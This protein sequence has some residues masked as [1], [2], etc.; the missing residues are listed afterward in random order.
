MKNYQVA[1]VFENIAD[2]MEID[3]DS[4]F[5]IRAYRQAAETMRSLTS[6]LEELAERGELQEIPGVGEAIEAKTLQILATGTCDLYERLRKKFPPSIIEL[7]SLPGVGARTVRSIYEGLHVASLEELKAAAQA[8]RL[9]TL[10][11]MGAKAEQRILEGIARLE[12]RPHGLPIVRALA[13]TES[14]TGQLAHLAGARAVFAAGDCRRYQEICAAIVAVAA[15]DNPSA[16]LKAFSGG[17]SKAEIIEERPD[18]VRVTSDLGPV[19]CY[20]EEPA[21]AG[22]ALVRATGSRTHLSHLEELAKE[23]GL[24]FA[25][26]RLTRKDG[27]PLEAPDEE[28]FY[29]LLGLPWIAPEIRE[30]GE[31]IAAAQAGRLPELISLPDI[32]GDLHS[33]TLDSDGAATAAEMAEA[34][35]ERGYQYLAITDHSQSLTVAR[36]LTPER[37]RAQ[38][39]VI[40]GINAATTG[41]LLLRGIEVDIKHDGS[42]DLPD[43]VLEELDW[44]N[45]SIH[46]AFGLPEE[47][48][49]ARAL[50]AV[51][52][53]HVDALSHPTGRQIGVRD[54][55]PLD[56]DAVINAALEHTT[57]LEIN[58]FPDRLDLCGP[59]ARRAR[60]AGVKIAISTDSHRPSHLAGIIHGIGTARRGWLTREDVLNT[61]SWDAI[62]QW[63]APK[64]VQAR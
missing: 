25:G 45:A 26:T 39:P 51:S 11:K 31:E 33:H 27:G 61:M 55:Y 62:R 12:A 46:S 29:R 32:V 17:F 20:V 36:G 8:G 28:T 10:P 5:K 48:M 42:L 63:K 37:V 59:D 43:D 35:R 44:V 15:S 18:M 30:T 64:A 54:P 47:E 7:L 2:L 14:L 19:V 4:P 60:D 13:A 6:N 40:A 49:T 16:T 3:G 34:A 50:R 22:G 9:R 21:F 24:E 1:S 58:S 23:R 52:S 56:L 57:A 53:P 38:A 41:F